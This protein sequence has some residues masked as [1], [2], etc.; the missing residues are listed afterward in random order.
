MEPIAMAIGL[1]ACAIL[2]FGSKRYREAYRTCETDQ[3]IHGNKGS[4]PDLPRRPAAVGI[5]PP[6]IA[7][8]NN[9]APAILYPFEIKILPMIPTTPIRAMKFRWNAAKPAIFIPRKIMEIVVMSLAKT[10]DILAEESRYFQSIMKMANSGG[11]CHA[12]HE[13]GFG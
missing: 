11:N 13:S 7:R 3:A 6:I 10:F 4:V 9:V 5:N 12:S 8:L 2:A 1:I